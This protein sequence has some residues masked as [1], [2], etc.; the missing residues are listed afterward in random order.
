MCWGRGDRCDPHLLCGLSPHSGV[1]RG[2][3][4]GLRERPPAPGMRRGRNGS[5]GSP[6]APAP[7]GKPPLSGPAARSEP[8]IGPEPARGPGEGFKRRGKKKIKFKINGERG[9]T[10]CCRGVD[11]VESVWR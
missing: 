9:K 5:S 8:R 3:P 7:S 4:R 10:S 11:A 2:A 6:P 1:A